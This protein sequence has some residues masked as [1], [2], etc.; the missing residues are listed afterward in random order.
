MTLLTTASAEL[1]VPSLTFE[2]VVPGDKKWTI[3]SVLAVAS[4]EPGGA[5]DRA[6]TLVVATSTGPVAAVGAPDNGTEP[7]TCTVTWT[8]APGS[9]VEAGN[10]GVSLAPFNPPEL[11]PGYTIVGTIIDPAAGDFWLS[12]TVWYEFVNTGPS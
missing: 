7:G 4:R 9:S 6:Y 5:P 2:F 8:N 12:A 1:L 10:Q 3:R 11:Q